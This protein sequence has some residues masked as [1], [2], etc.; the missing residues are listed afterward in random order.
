MISYLIP[1]DLVF[2]YLKQSKQTSNRHSS[3][4]KDFSI[5]FLVLSLHSSQVHPGSY[6]WCS[7]VFVNVKLCLWILKVNLSLSLFR[8]YYSLLFHTSGTVIPPIF[9]GSSTRLVWHN[10]FSKVTNFWKSI[11]STTSSLISDRDVLV[12]PEPCL[13]N[14][15]S[16]HECSLFRKYIR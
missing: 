4:W 2:I 10:V 1:G 13:S 5:T 12:L 7:L 11:L 16:Q 3:Q 14:E 8:L 6:P 15:P 9:N